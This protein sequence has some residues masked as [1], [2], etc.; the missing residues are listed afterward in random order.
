MGVANIQGYTITTP[1]IV[2][3]VAN[4]GEA[5][6]TM[7]YVEGSF[8]FAKSQIKLELQKFVN[9]G[10]PWWENWD[11]LEHAD[12]DVPLGPIDVEVYST[13]YMS[14]IIAY[15]CHKC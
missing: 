7:G 6:E 14:C 10:K 3:E 2:R 9:V 11:A 5:M 8:V 1:S 4:L 12:T 13:D 15:H